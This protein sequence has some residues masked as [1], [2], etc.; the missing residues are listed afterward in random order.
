MKIIVAI[1]TMLFCVI[2][3]SHSQTVNSVISVTP[4]YSAANGLGADDKVKRGD[5]Q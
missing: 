3:T 4:T 1:M 5:P 2:G